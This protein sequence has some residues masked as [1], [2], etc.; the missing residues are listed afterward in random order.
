MPLTPLLTPSEKKVLGFLVSK[1]LLIAPHIN[2]VRS[3]KLRISDA[4]AVGLNREPRVL[5]VLPAAILHFPKSFLD[6]DT[7]PE[8]LRET[9]ECIKK[10]K[11]TGP[12]LGGIPYA[13]MM[14]WANETLPDKRTRPERE[15]KITKAFRLS[16]IALE[17]LAQAASRAAISETAFIE[18]WLREGLANESKLA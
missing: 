11:E 6:H 3:A 2:P 12:S 7:M 5:E 8:K 10:G 15:R 18:R 13:A 17:N 9:L 4:I 14:R 1:G 16:R